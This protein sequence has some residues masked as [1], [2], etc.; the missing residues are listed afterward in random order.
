MKW[1][2]IIIRNTVGQAMQRLFDAKGVFKAG[3]CD[4]LNVL[5]CD[6]TQSEAQPHIDHYNDN[7]NELKGYRE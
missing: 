7:V 3:Y 6:I 2:D 1:D 5:E 4:I